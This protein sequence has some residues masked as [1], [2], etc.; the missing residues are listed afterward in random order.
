MGDRRQEKQT[1]RH[2]SV[3][4]CSAALLRWTEGKDRQ[5]VVSRRAGTTPGPRQSLQH[6]EAGVWSREV[7][8]LLLVF[9]CTQPWALKEPTLKQED[10]AS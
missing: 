7:L 3:H 2:T 8:S 9:K 4:Y 5:R 1:C 6:A 10:V